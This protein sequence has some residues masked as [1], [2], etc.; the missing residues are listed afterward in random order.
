MSEPFVIDIVSDVVCPWC[1]LGKMQ[2]EAALLRMPE[3][4]AT[5]RWHPFQL[6]STIPPDGLDRKAYMQKSLVIPGV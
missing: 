1:Y 5:I 2:L 4:E 6:D 3:L